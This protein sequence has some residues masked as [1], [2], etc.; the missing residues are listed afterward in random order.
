[1]TGALGRLRRLEAALR[2]EGIGPLDLLTDHRPPEPLRH[3][4]DGDLYDPRSAAQAYFHVHRPQESGH[5]HL[6]LRPAGMPAGM[7]PLVPAAG[8]PK[9]PCHLGAV[10]LD[11]R[12]MPCALFATN[13]WVTGEAWFAAADVAL[14]LVRFRLDLPPPHD[15]LGRWLSA[16]GDV[17]RP[18]LAEL[19]RRRD[20]ALADLAGGRSL[21]DRLEDETLE[22]LAR[23]PL[24]PGPGAGMIPANL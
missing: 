6:F 19:A 4:P 15:R 13:R 16:L 17:H 21:E 23:M 1:M 5:I 7:V 3:Y 20:A 11:H 8:D 18:A 14:L 2:A 10:E 24:P 9:A 22:V 12:G